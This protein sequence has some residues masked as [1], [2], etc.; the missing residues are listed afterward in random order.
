H[1]DTAPEQGH[2][3]SPKHPHVTSSLRASTEM[4]PPVNTSN[5]TNRAIAAARDHS[6]ATSSSPQ[7]ASSHG[8]TNVVS[9]TRW[10]ACPKIL[11]ASTESANACGFF[12]FIQAANM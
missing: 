9:T 12:N 10:S 3:Y 2:S 8:T 6:P 5:C 4:I 1:I 7:I 11:N